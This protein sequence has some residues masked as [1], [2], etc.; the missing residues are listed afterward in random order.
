MGFRAVAAWWAVGICLIAAH[1]AW[2]LDQ[3]VRTPIPARYDYDEGVYAATAD[4]VAGGDR[5]YRDVFLSQPPVLIV[6]MRGMFRLL[7]PSLVAARGTVV[8]S[9]AVYLLAILTL[10]STRGSPGGGVLAVCLLLGRP[11]F[12]TMSHTVEMELPGEALA[13]TALALAVMGRR[14]G[15]GWWAAAGGAATL[16]SMTKLTAVTCLIPLAGAVALER[17]EGLPGRCAAVGVGILAA[18]FMLIPVVALPGFRD[19]V[20]GFHLLLAH[21]LHQTASAHA[22]VL[23]R[24]LLAEWPL[25]GLGL[26]GTWWA[27]RE[28][29]WLERALVVWLA[30]DCGGL[31]VLTPLWDHHLPILFSP[32]ALLAGLVLGRVAAWATAG[33]PA[34]RP[35]RYAAVAVGGIGFLAVA[36]AAM[37]PMHA[38]A[39]LGRAVTRLAGALPTNGKVLSDDP[40]VAFLAHRAL[41]ARLID[42][43]LTRIWVGQ[44]SE[45]QLAAALREERTAAVV[46]WRGTFRQYFPRFTAA[47][48]RLFPIE[49]RSGRGR[50]VL[51][52]REAA[53]SRP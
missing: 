20:F 4:A 35:A 30:A 33:G 27:V 29:R 25:S 14:R 31:I 10:L 6:A 41:A 44:I 21:A 2:Q 49:A 8:L 17:R 12:L 34:W 24:F 15:W 50:V 23:G 28:G 40:M 19:Q 47:A 16:A 51:L 53:P 36:L 9:S 22:A 43:S 46:L 13:C 7:G 48:V 1:T 26:L 52:M 39:E 5:L 38:S 32:L 37:P 11:T 3:V 18:A 45:G 42:T